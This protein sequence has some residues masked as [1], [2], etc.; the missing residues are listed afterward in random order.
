MTDTI[1]PSTKINI[2]PECNRGTP[3]FDDGNVIVMSQ[4]LAFRVYKGIVG[5]YS[6]LLREMLET[7]ATE[8]IGGCPAIQLDDPTV[9]ISSFLTVIHGCERAFQL[10]SKQEFSTLVG[11][12]RMATKYKAEA[13]RQRALLPLQRI[14]PSKLSQW[15]EVFESN[16]MLWHLDP[17]TV[18]NVA[19]E[20]AAL[21]I[22]PA[23]MAFLANSTLAQEAF[24]VSIFQTQPLRFAPGLL[25]A[26][27]LKAFSLM[28]EY[29]HASVAKTLRFIREQSKE[30]HVSCQRLH[31]VDGCSA[32][33]TGIFV[34]LSVVVAT[35]EAPAGYPSFVI[36]VQGVSQREDLCGSC[37]DR[38]D[39]GL[40]RRRRAWWRGLPEALGFSGWDDA[41]LR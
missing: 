22:L 29:N 26:E 36:T 38:F 8:I 11:V 32:K 4:N 16:S 5:Q 41:R 17:V 28:K 12:L 40:D 34:A 9:D 7:K 14:Y 1:I 31:G 20:V 13:L 15:D 6:P 23:A 10:S 33:F 35:S 25:S 3:W 39:V 19:R 37:R 24:G 30:R 18:T 21:S 27:D 2:I